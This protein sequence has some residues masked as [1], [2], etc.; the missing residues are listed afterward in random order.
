MILI[1]TIF[2]IPHYHCLPIRFEKYAFFRLKDRN[3][4]PNPY[5]IFL[6]YSKSYKIPS[7]SGH[8]HGAVSIM[9]HVSCPSLWIIFLEYIFWHCGFKENSNTYCLTSI[10]YPGIKIVEQRHLFSQLL[11]L[12][13]GNWAVPPLALF[14]FQWDSSCIPLWSKYKCV[15]APAP[16]NIQREHRIASPIFRLVFCAWNGR[17]RK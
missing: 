5:I 4:F 9:T 15:H 10:F 8:L 2:A 1:Y 12:Q 17:R 3:W 13:I 14:S 6:P 16:G 7:W 11:A